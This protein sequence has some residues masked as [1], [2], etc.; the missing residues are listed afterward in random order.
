VTEGGRRQER[1]LTNDEWR[2]ALAEHFGID[3]TGL[4]P[5]AG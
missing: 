5:G 4:L 2:S 3:P 1:Q